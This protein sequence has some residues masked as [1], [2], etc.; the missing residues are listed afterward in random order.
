M[1]TLRLPFQKDLKSATI[2]SILNDPHDP[3]VHERYS[4]ELKNLV[5]SLLT[6]DPE[7]RPSIKQLIQ[8]PIIRNAVMLL[9]REFEGKT[10][11]ELITALCENDDSFKIDLPRLF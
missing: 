11:F 5:S 7:H 10:Y 3:I 2:A 1:C 6:K 9:L 8:V 4:K